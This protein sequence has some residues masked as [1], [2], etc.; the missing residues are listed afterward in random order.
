MNGHNSERKYNK[1]LKRKCYYCKQHGHYIGQCPI[2]QKDECRKEMK[3]KAIQYVAKCSVR[4]IVNQVIQFIQDE[5]KSYEKIKGNELL[6][7][8][9]LDELYYGIFNNNIRLRNTTSYSI[10][11]NTWKFLNQL[12]NNKIKTIKNEG[13]DKETVFLMLKEKV[14][15]SYFAK[16]QL[17]HIVKR[18]LN[19]ATVVKHRVT[20]GMIR[21]HQQHKQRRLAKKQ[22]LKQKM[23]AEQKKLDDL[24]LRKSIADNLRQVVNVTQQLKSIKFEDV[25]NDVIHGD[26][27]FQKMLPMQYSDLQTHQTVT[28]P[29]RAIK[30]VRNGRKST[31]FSSKQ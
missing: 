10:C 1:I 17:R 3:N 27:K 18:E 4:Q 30:Q 2:K 19:T 29:N 12:I 26:Q 11:H 21:R 28:Q 6:I 20:E 14:N 5:I 31:R 25:Y 13:I 15:R 7:V 8:N 22:A 23:D 24:Y 16:D 9:Q